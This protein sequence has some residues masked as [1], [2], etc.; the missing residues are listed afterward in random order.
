[1]NLF[2]M[3]MNPRRGLIY[4]MLALAEAGWLAPVLLGRIDHHLTGL[5]GWFFTLLT[6]IAL[7]ILLGWLTDVYRVP[8]EGA[9]GAGL[10]LAG[11]SV[12]A[13]LKAT[14]FPEVGFWQL[15]WLG[16]FGRGLFSAGTGYGM[17]L[18]WVVLAI[19]YIWWRCLGLGHAPPEPPA[20]QITLRIG[21][22]AYFVLMIFGSLKPEQMPPLSFLMLFI[23]FGL[24]AMTFS[25]TQTITERHGEAAVGDFRRR[26]IN[27]LAIV[28]LVIFSAMVLASV[29]SFP[30]VERIFSILGIILGVLLKPIGVLLLWLV[31]LLGPFIEWLVA[32]LQSIAAE[33]ASVAPTPQPQA[34][35]MP[36]DA[37]GPVNREPAW[38]AVY[39]LWGLRGA[40]VLLVI[41][42]FY[43][44]T[45]KLGQ[46][47]RQNQAVTPDTAITSES[48]SPEMPGLGG[49][50]ERGKNKL[51]DLAAMIRQFGLGKELRAAATIKRIYAALMALASEHNLE[52]APAQTPLEFLGPLSQCWPELKS[53]FSVITD[54]YV[55]VHYGQLP[56]GTAGLEAVQQAWLEIYDSMVK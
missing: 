18:A 52:R 54:A 15:G 26:G 50:F 6:V 53:Q 1:M 7:A 41:W 46:R 23:G 33:S 20:A 19:G 37:M 47:F 12:P 29:F 32:F 55:N 5:G 51:A 56:E 49:L 21:F 22:A 38:W 14:L 4:A 11:L 45:G 44:F 13:L 27:N 40:G 10:A 31:E 30:V 43:K 42:I 3:P 24:L 39:L 48:I 8:L 35:P 17:A 34:T 36:L 2:V 9:R 16:D 28:T 25:Y